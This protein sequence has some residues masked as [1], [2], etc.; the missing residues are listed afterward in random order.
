MT[1]LNAFTTAFIVLLS[2]IIGI[3]IVSIRSSQKCNK[4][5]KLDR[6]LFGED[7]EE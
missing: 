1:V 4:T 5:A 7:N 2:L 6:E 3:A